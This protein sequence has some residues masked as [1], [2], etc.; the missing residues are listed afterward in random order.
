MAFAQSTGISNVMV[1]WMFKQKQS[2]KM[3]TSLTSIWIHFHI[4]ILESHFRH[5]SK[6]D[7]I[8]QVQTNSSSVILNLYDVYDKGEL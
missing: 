8:S 6:Y 3:K 5:K 7:K 4:S 1:E 2:T